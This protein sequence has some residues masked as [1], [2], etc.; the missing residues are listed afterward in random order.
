MK[1]LE[2]TP[3]FSF[4]LSAE[5]QEALKR[6]AEADDRSPSALARKIITD[7]LKRQGKTRR[8]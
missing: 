8:N 4:R 1:R 6:A 3:M 2:V 5:L 7:W